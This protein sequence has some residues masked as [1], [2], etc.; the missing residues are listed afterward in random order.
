MTRSLARLVLLVTIVAG[1]HRGPG[2]CPAGTRSTVEIRDG[3]G[4]LELAV[5]GSQVCDGQLHHV[6]DLA[7]GPDGA[8]LVRAAGAEPTAPA[9]LSLRRDSDS[10][11][12]VQAPTGQRYRL[13]RDPKELRVLQPDGVPLGSIVNDPGAGVLYNPQQSPL[14]RVQRR[15]RDAVVTNLSG[16]T[17]TYVV[18]AADPVAAGVFGLPKLSRLDQLA[19]YLYW[20]R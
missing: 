13:Y 8:L 15:D 19:I 7:N 10:V 2:R 16:T 6:A 12:L 17:L 20:S 5:K 1:C 4:A 14:G 3:N 18:P 9:L 11:A